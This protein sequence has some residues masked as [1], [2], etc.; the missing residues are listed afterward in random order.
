MDQQ[1]RRTRFEAVFADVYEPIQRYLRRRC[2][3]HDVDD[4]VDEVLVTLWRRLD[5]VPVDA[6]LPWSYGVARGCLANHRRGVRR[7]LQLEQ[8]LAGRSGAAPADAWTGPVDARL[9]SALDRLSELDR[10]VVRLWA[11]EQL[12]PREIA[13]VLG[14][15]S[16]AVS[17]RL[18][19]VR[20]RLRSELARKDPAGAG[21]GAIEDHSE[22]ER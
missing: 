22:L 10:E 12:E 7:R 11:W 15:T 16:G 4:V 17:V 3:A 14:T 19:R 5:D 21:H 1:A 6:V 9:A 13:D 2:A 18:N 8:R 20:N